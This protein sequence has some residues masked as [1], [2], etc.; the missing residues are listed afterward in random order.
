LPGQNKV[1]IEALLADSAQPDHGPSAPVETSH[2]AYVIFTSGSTGRPKGVMVQHGNVLNFFAGMDKALG[3]QQPGRWLA[4]TSISFDISVLE[5]FWTLSR[6]FEV[7]LQGELD[8]TSLAKLPVSSRSDARMGFSLFYFAASTNDAQKSDAYRLLL[9]G[10]RF[11]DTH[12]FDAVWTPE[13]HFHEFG[14]LYPNPAVTSAALATITSRVQLRAGSI[15]LPLHSPLRVAEDWA[16]IDNLSGGRVGMSFASG[17]HVNDFAFMPHNYE[18]RRE[19]MLES[20]ETVRK[21]WRGEKVSV[22]N[23]AGK[24]IEVSVLPR[25]LNPNPAVWVASAGNVETFELAGRHGFNVLTNMLGQDLEDLANKLRA[26]RRARAAAGHSGP[27]VVSVMLHT[28]VCEDTEKARALARKPFS[29]YLATSFDL[30]KVAPWM[31]PAFKQ[32]SREAAQDPTF[33]P[34]S[35][36]DEDMEAL[37]D[38]AFDRYFETAGLFGSPEHALAMVDRLKGIGVD[39][40]ACLIDFGIE[41]D[42]ALRGLTH[43]DHLREL[44]N[45]SA[46]QRDASNEDYGIAAQLVRHGITHL[47]CTPSM[48]R[49]LLSDPEARSALRGV[50]K[51]MLG[52]EALPRDLADPLLALVGGDIL[53]MYGPTETTV[54]STTSRVDATPITIG[55]PIANTVIRILDPQH[56]LAPIGVPGEL[57]IG[58]AGVVRGYL[59]RP[60]L[61]RERFIA[62]PLEPTARLYRTGDLA[63]YREDGALEFLGRLDH[64]V[65]ISG[66]R[67]ELGE[68]ESAIARH[69]AVRQNVVVARN[70][71]GTSE[72]VAYLVTQPAADAGEAARVEQWRSLWDETYKQA[73]EQANARFNIAGWRDSFTGAPIPPEHMREWL[74]ATLAR[75]LAGAPK[76]VLEIGCGTGM[77]LYGSLAHVE[78]YTAVDVSPHALDTIRGELREG[79]LEKVTLINQAAHALSGLEPR[80]YDAVIINSV[81][82]YFPDAEYLRSVLQRASELVAD[83]GRIVIG[84]VRDLNHLRAFHA[85]IELT[86]A[87]AGRGAAELSSRIDRRLEREGELLVNE[88]WFRAL[89]ST[90]PRIAGVDVQLKRGAAHNEMSCYRLDVVLFVG[91][92]AP[93]F[94]LPAA[95]TEE[96][97]GVLRERPAVVYVR[98]LPNARLTGIYAA[99]AALADGR[100]DAAGLRA[101]CVDSGLEP[102]RVYALDPAYEASL[103]PARSG[104]P[105][106][107]DAVLRH[108]ELGPVGLPAWPEPSQAARA[109]QPARASHGDE[110]E[111]E[112]RELLRSTLPAYMVPSHFVQLSALPLTPNQKIDRKA[113]PAPVRAA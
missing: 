7:V 43:L 29:R 72:L 77:I 111:R 11:A 110:L 61:T 106:R 79:E 35:F 40:V 31:F 44:S 36:T 55:Q 67:I 54:W 49:M 37:L 70:D 94:A 23:G 73:D 42:E 30:V 109:N 101:R 15:V 48:A 38:H 47:Q 58:G 69:P 34:T 95:R 86:Q 5:L 59:G 9:E 87:P 60:D 64:Q 51:L 99:L 22:T 41:T 28:F 102:E 50:R 84:D 56:Q 39:E 10:A 76:R 96:L 8:R 14:G 83:G 21:L 13:R 100:E 63:R 6:G 33:D 66:Y 27:G 53:N 65:K 17:W 71:R 108:R 57:C 91:R 3:H 62:D 93:R 107:F 52:G 88:A 103:V 80:S 12:D 92:D 89:P 19:V 18:R 112:L 85:Q 82:Q 45:P 104:D 81:A 74:D 25:P 16:V 4:V 68:I 24:P 113:L 32:P 97:E 2:L 98:D 105:T 20:I 75:V 1:T 90:L 78:H 26:Y 46:E